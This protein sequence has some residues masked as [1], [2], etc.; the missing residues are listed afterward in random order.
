METM[1]IL[2]RGHQDP[3]DCKPLSDLGSLYISDFLWWHTMVL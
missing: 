1:K 3:A 2:F